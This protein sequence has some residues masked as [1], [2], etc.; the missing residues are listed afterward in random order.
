MYV[1]GFAIDDSLKQLAERCFD[2]FGT[3]VEETAIGK[4]QGEEERIPGMPWE[5]TSG[6]PSSSSNQQSLSIQ[7]K[8]DDSKKDSIGPK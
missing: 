4:K 6:L 2:I 1:L 8:H 5:P 3:G 7:D